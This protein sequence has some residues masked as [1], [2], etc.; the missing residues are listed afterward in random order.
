MKAEL[1]NKIANRGD[2]ISFV[3]FQEFMFKTIIPIKELSDRKG[4]PLEKILAFWRRKELTPFIGHGKWMKISFA[5]LIWLRILDD[6]R[7]ISFP[8]EKMK[9]VCDYFFKDAYFDSLPEKNLKH[10]KEE[11]IKKLAAGTQTEDDEQYLSELE[12]YLANPTILYIFKFDI[13]YLVNLIAFVISSGNDGFIYIFFD[14]KVAEYIGQGY[15]GHRDL[16][17]DFNEPHICLSISHYLKEFIN[18]EELSTL[19]MPQLLNEDEIKV[20]REMRRNNIKEITI[21]RAN[22]KKGIRIESTKEGVL[23]KE[24]AKQIKELLGMKNYERITIDTMDEKTL[25]FKMTRKKI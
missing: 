5:Q 1:K 14:G 9:L 23:S 18:D 4:K 24:Q 20:L 10:N 16:E 11:I 8:I 13:N 3:E 17:I 2:L 21:R 6:L 12:Y 15:I 25:S 7:E 19:L 22:D